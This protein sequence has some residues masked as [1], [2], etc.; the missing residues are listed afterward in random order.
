MEYCFK[1]MKWV[2]LF[3]RIGLDR[4]VDWEQKSSVL[5]SIVH[6][7][8]AQMRERRFHS[9]SLLV[10]LLLL[11]WFLQDFLLL[12][13]LL[14][15]SHFHSL[16][17]TLLSFQLVCVWEVHV[18]ERCLLQ[19]KVYKEIERS[20]ACKDFISLSFPLTFAYFVIEHYCARRTILK[21]KQSPVLDHQSNSPQK[22]RKQKHQ[23]HYFQ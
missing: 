16:H 11:L 15:Q 14:L 2:L 13:E 8:H 9:C 18:V 21:Y 6:W 22:L 3:Q 7:K 20:S 12:I 17:W 10:L 4:D 19:L 5:V 1:L 23:V